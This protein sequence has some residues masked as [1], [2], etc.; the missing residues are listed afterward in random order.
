VRSR[1]TLLSPEW[2]PAN[3]NFRN[4]HRNL[5][6]T[7]HRL[8]LRLIAKAPLLSGRSEKWATQREINDWE[9]DSLV[10]DLCEIAR[11]PGG[12]AMLK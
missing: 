6:S 8:V 12:L 5:N 7:L 2:P 3:Q 11:K 9:R 1:I 4:F 10:E